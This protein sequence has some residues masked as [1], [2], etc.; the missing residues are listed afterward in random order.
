MKN[1]SK[2]FLILIFCFCS[3]GSFAYKQ[4]NLQELISQSDLIV[5]G[6]I[7]PSSEAISEMSS[8]LT[9]KVEVQKILKGNSETP[10]LISLLIPL[11]SY[12][13]IQNNGHRIF[14]LKNSN[15]YYLPVHPA[16]FSRVFK[17]S[18]IRQI[19]EELEKIRIFNEI[20]QNKA[21]DEKTSELL[22]EFPEKWIFPNI[23]SQLQK[24]MVCN[25]LYITPHGK[26]T[27]LMNFQ[28]SNNIFEFSVSG[29]V[30][31][32]KVYFNENFQKIYNDCL[33]FNR[34]YIPLTR[35]KFV[36]PVIKG[37]IRIFP[38][39]YFIVPVLYS[40]PKLKVIKEEWIK[41]DSR[42]NQFSSHNLISEKQIIDFL[43]KYSFKYRNILHLERENTLTLTRTGNGK[44]QTLLLPLPDKHHLFFR[45]SLKTDKFDEIQIK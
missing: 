31:E 24:E 23:S 34:K 38:N 33:F 10:R 12:R 32:D 36:S 43:E 3:F 18:F 16:N 22:E 28:L 26:L 42:K 15:S 1:N 5:R 25:K 13:S 8:S 6:K 7:I 17:L 45:W 30:L 14:F 40:C 2:I 9:I 27:G 4:Q 39:S 35:K 11:D 37:N 41:C 44:N 19:E 21:V 29:K 20:S